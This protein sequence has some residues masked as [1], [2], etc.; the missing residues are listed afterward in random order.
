MNKPNSTTT[1]LEQ[2]LETDPR[3]NYAAIA[4]NHAF[5]L[6]NHKQEKEGRI[7]QHGTFV[8]RC[9][10]KLA[11]LSGDPSVEN[12]AF[13]SALNHMAK[14]A[15]I[16]E[17]VDGP[18]GVKRVGGS[19]KNL[20][21]SILRNQPKLSL[22]HLEILVNT[23]RY[24]R[25]L[26]KD[27]SSYIKWNLDHEVHTKGNYW[28]KFP[29]SKTLTGQLRKLWIQ[30]MS[31]NLYNYNPNISYT[32]GLI[33]KLIPS[34][35][36]S[37][38]PEVHYLFCRL[39]HD[40]KIDSIAINNYDDILK[41]IWKATDDDADLLLI[42]AAILLNSVNEKLCAWKDDPK[43][44]QSTP[45]SIPKPSTKTTPL[46]KSY[47][48]EA[49]IKH[50]PTWPKLAGEFFHLQEN[51]VSMKDFCQ[52]NRLSETAF[53]DFYRVVMEDIDKT[54]KTDP[55]LQKLSRLPAK[56]QNEYADLSRRRLQTMQKMCDAASG[57]I[58]EKV[59][60]KDMFGNGKVN[61]YI[62]RKLNEALDRFKSIDPHLSATFTLSIL[63]LQ[64]IES[65]L[66]K[67]L[68]QH[69]L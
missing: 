5:V 3:T 67:F 52:K 19:F 7:Y 55:F 26:P 47:D 68:L 54:V 29:D 22:T 41:S 10:N 61:K 13:L 30:C 48:I 37:D 16:C 18:E 14:T 27:V 33:S 11:E 60:I 65:K 38:D 53:T 35:L 45:N 69:G 34:V 44:R 8:A 23:R 63:E 39:I 59:E 50:H 25:R 66:E 20:A 43:L 32:Q 51:G 24:N 4:Y 57:I 40:G 2:L 49:T 42:N 6:A 56:D 17:L 31:L 1:S 15:E 64:D 36:Q 28:D 46:N 21:E 62:E 12:E 9:I 58:G